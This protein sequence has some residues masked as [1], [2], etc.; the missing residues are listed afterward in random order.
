[1]YTRIFIF[2]ETDIIHNHKLTSKYYTYTD[3]DIVL[4][5]SS[6]NNGYI[7][8]KRLLFKSKFI[9]KKKM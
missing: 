8:Y 6:L 7:H 3:K 5:T 1:M 4:F 2:D 9:F